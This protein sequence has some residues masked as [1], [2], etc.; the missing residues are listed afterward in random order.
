MS[1]I[2]KLICLTVPIQHCNLKCEY[3]YISRVKDWNEGNSSFDFSIDHIINCLSN[4]YTCRGNR[5]Y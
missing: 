3:C 5:N 2:K 4:T 1:K